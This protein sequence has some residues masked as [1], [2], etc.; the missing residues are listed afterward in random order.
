MPSHVHLALLPEAV[1]ELIAAV[2]FVAVLLRFLGGAVW[3][4]RRWR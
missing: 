3:T 2:I 1:V 4:S